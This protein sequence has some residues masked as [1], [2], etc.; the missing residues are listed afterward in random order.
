MADQDWKPK[1]HAH[2]PDAAPDPQPAPAP[3]PQRAPAA[4]DKP[5]DEKTA[6]D[7]RAED[8]AVDT[9]QLQAEKQGIQ[10]AADSAALEQYKSEQVA[11]FPPDSDPLKDRE[12]RRADDKKH[13]GEH[14]HHHHHPDDQ[15]ATGGE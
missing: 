11:Q 1:Q 3:E 14:G 4:A 12:T 2:H 5:Q 8:A 15:A 13:H 9:D 10:D 7:L 6:G